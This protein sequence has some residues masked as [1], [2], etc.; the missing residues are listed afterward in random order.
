MPAPTD[1]GIGIAQDVHCLLDGDGGRDQRQAELAG[2]R[3]KGLQLLEA[4]AGQQELA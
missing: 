2:Q 3:P 4:G 1:V